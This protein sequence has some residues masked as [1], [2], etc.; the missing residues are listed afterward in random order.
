MLI[1]PLAV[2]RAQARRICSA[3]CGSAFCFFSSR[4][5]RR[6]HL[7][8]FSGDLARGPSRPSVL[9]SRRGLGVRMAVGILELLGPR[10]M[11]FTRFPIGQ[12]WKIFPDAPP[13][14]YLAFPGVCSRN[15]FAPVRI[16]PRGSSAQNISPKKKISRI[17]G[18]RM[19]SRYFR[20]L[21]CLAIAACAPVFSRA[22]A[23]ASETRYP[24]RKQNKPST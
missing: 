16:R 4:S 7:P 11:G 17:A 10:R 21:F 8:S 13:P 20:V 5:N 24:P 23:C 6:L 3:W 1:V 9:F 14:G 19:P 18:V 15:V 22:K 2:T 12:H